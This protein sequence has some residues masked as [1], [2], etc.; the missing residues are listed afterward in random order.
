[1]YEVGFYVVIIAKDF[2][3]GD[4]YVVST[5]PGRIN[6]LYDTWSDNISQSI[7]DVIHEYANVPIDWIQPKIMGTFTQEDKVD[8]IYGCRVPSDTALLRGG[9]VK[10]NIDDIKDS[11]LQQIICLAMR[12]I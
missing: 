5:D 4:S 6:L 2:L 1:M 9:W 7:S 12:N 8:I 10:I 3:S 11:T